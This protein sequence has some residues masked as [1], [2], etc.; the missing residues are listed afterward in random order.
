MSAS[1]PRGSRA[2]STAL[3]AAVLAFVLLSRPARAADDSASALA[4]SLFE[5][6]KELLDSGRVA[7]ACARLEESQRLA[8][9]GGTLLVLGI[10]RAREGRTATAWT[11]L[12]NALALARRSARNDRVELAERQMKELSPR[13]AYLVLVVHEASPG[14]RAVLTLDGV[15]I[16]RGGWD[17]PLMVDPGDHVLVISATGYDAQTLAVHV[18]EGERHQLDVPLPAPKVVG[19]DAPTG[20]RVNASPAAHGRSIGAVPKERDGIGAQRILAL[21]LAGTAVAELGLGAYFGVSAVRKEHR[22]KASC[23]STDGACITHERRLDEQTDQAARLSNLA[24]G[25]AAVTAGTS[26]YLFLDAPERTRRTGS[27][28]LRLEGTARRDYVGASLSGEF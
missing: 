16:Q 3:T 28:E 21:A 11:V 18:D 8:P 17:T 5:E 25:L 22:K 7:E 15:V 2:S 24:F 9:G 12:K 4:D 1:R 6:G 20:K 13:L 14:A 26:L 19:G 23:A 27:T 10:C